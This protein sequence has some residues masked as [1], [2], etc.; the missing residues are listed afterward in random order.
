MYGKGQ[1]VDVD[2]EEYHLRFSSQITWLEDHKLVFGIDYSQ[3]D[4]DYSFDI[5]P[6]Y[7]TETD[8]DCN[9]QKGERIQDVA[10]LKNTD[11]AIYLHDIWSINEDWQL[12]LG[13]R[14]ERND[15][16]E[17]DFIHPRLALDWLASDNLVIKAK[18]GTYSRF[19][20]IDTALNKLGNVS[21]L[22]SPYSGKKLSS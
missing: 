2:E 16:T 17:Q 8:A 1:F 3:S 7:C 9:Q 5:I 11:T 13:L 12:T 14:G 19:P 6:Y 15:Y 20:D 22:S 4:V 18:A 21:A 10:N